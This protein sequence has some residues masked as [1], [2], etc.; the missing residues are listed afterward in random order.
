MKK[1]FI[2]MMVLMLTLASCGKYKIT[3]S[4]KEE[5]V[6]STM[7]IVTKDDN[8]LHKFHGNKIKISS[9]DNSKDIVNHNLIYMDI[10]INYITKQ[11][12]ILQLFIMMT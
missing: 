6:G 7:L 8:L 3:I 2:L 5:K 4:E 12:K 10:L 9:N 11:M 1:I